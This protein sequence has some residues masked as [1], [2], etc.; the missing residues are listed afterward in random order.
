MWGIVIW[1]FISYKSFYEPMMTQIIRFSS[2]DIFTQNRRWA[3]I[4]INDNNPAYWYI[5]M[6]L[7]AQDNGISIAD[8]L[9]IL[10]SCTKASIIVLW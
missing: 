2:D 10:Q 6:A 1:H 4:C 3:I 8:A 5:P 9:E 7:P